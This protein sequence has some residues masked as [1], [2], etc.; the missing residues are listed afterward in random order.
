MSTAAAY[1]SKSGGPLDVDRKFYQRL[2]ESQDR[3]LIDKFVIP[4]RSGKAWKV[5]AG[6][7]CRI[8][9]ITGL[10]IFEI[11]LENYIFK[12]ISKNLISAQKNII[13]ENNIFNK[14]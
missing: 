5:P 1:Q 10:K 7:L 2:A 8:I 12:S 4:I 3:E 14:K 6:Y 9:A 13:K 11:F